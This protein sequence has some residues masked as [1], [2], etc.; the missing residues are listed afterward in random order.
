MGIMEKINIFIK[1]YGVIIIVLLF[2][3]FY[4]TKY[5]TIKETMICDLKRPYNN[6]FFKNQQHLIADYNFRKKELRL[7]KNLFDKKTFLK[8]G[9]N[10]DNKSL[11]EFLKLN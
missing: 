4:Y 10:S 11:S 1:K 7:L 2:I 3:F 9:Y 5:G 6:Y 8:N